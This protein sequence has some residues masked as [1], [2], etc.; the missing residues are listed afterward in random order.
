VAIVSERRAMRSTAW[1]LTFLVLAASFAVVPWEL[2]VGDNEI[3]IGALAAFVFFALA[4]LLSMR[5][6]SDNSAASWYRGRAAAESTKTTAWRYAV[7]GDPFGTEMETRE[8]DRLFEERLESVLG[9]MSDIS[10][11][12][13]S[14]GEQITAGM[15][16]L[17]AQPLG[18]RKEVY[19]HSRIA[20]Q[21]AWYDTNSRRNGRRAEIWSAT[22]LAAN[23][24]GLV[25]AA[26]RVAEVPFFSDYDLLGIAAGFA[27]AATAWLQAKQ[28]KVLATSYAVA[29]HELSLIALRL[30]HIDREEEWSAFVRD[31][32]T[33][34]SR[35]HTLWLTRRGV[36][37]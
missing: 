11:R 26:L 9:G 1:E 8:A 35:E 24:A 2:D 29:A 23:F 36:A 10:W 4:L 13:A 34:I 16:A 37:G 14:T 33:A 18:V 28:F 30:P 7:G 12:G 17:R 32:E 5:V 25:A 20:D 3:A 27:A 31:A 15:R 21:E 22:A 6:T 19:A